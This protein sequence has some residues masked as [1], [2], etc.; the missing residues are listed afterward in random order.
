VDRIPDTT[1]IGNFVGKELQRVKGQR[2]RDN[3][4]IA[5]KTERRWK[6]NHSEVLEQPEH[7]DGRIKLQAGSIRHSDRQTQGREHC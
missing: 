5:K 7:D 4:G 2:N 1:H 6:V 3:D